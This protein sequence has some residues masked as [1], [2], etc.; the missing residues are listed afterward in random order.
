[1][2]K[3]WI[4]LPLNIKCKDLEDFKYNLKLELKPQRIKHYSKGSKNGNSLLTRLRVGQSELN[5]H[6]FSVG[7]V[8][9][10]DCICHANEESTK[11]FLI[12]CFL[13][14]TERQKL[15][16]LV[17]HYIPKFK[18]LFKAANILL[19]GLKT[20]DPDFDHLNFIITK[21]VQNFIIQIKKF[22]NY[23]PNSSLL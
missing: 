12:D 14:T 4:N 5:L 10:P 19:Y 16:L 2:T 9:K 3:L 8:E 18:G 11:H 22:L 21:A 6:K 13:Y 15:F 20:N 17:E 7:Q 23:K 1:M